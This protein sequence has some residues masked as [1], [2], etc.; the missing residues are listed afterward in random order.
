MRQAGRHGRA[1]PRGDRVGE[2]ERRHGAGHVEG[3]STPPP[4]SARI[5]CTASGAPALT[6]SVAPSARAKAS[7]S[8]EE[9]DGDDLARAGGIAPMTAPR[10]TPPSPTTATEAPAE[11]SPC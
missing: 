10:P 4:V 8:S 5:A 7:L 11:L 9:I 3:D 6:A 2:F 1:A